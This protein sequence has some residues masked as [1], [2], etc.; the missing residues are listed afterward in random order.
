MVQRCHRL[1]QRCHWS[2]QRCQR[3]TAAAIDQ[4]QQVVTDYDNAKPFDEIPGPRGLPYLGT[5][6]EYRKGM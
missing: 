3:S 2:E 6:L 1:V 5:M 4:D